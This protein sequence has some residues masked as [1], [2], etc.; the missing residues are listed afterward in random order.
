MTGLFA[1]IGAGIGLAFGLSYRGKAAARAWAVFVE[2][3]L[4]RPLES[5]LQAG[6]SED[7]EFKASARWDSKQ[8]RMNAELGNAVARGIAG[9]LN[10]RGGTLV[11]GVD[12]SSEVIG[13]ERDYGTLKRQDRDGFEQFVMSLV[14]SKLGGDICSLIHVAFEQADGRDVCRIIAEPAPRP[15]YYEEAGGACFYVRAGNT[16]RAL[17]VR[18]AIGHIADRWPGAAET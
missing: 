10:H 3:E 14:T 6:E 16:T 18:E 12:D 8:G 9:F 11:V 1:A 5:L 7:L 2:R 17:D 15:V 13:L 4:S